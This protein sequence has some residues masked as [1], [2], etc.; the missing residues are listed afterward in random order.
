VRRA[1]F[2]DRWDVFSMAADGTG[3]QYQPPPTRDGKDRMSAGTQ[4]PAFLST[5]LLLL[6]T[7]CN[8]APDGDRDAHYSSGQLQAVVDEYLTDKT[9][10]LGTIVK[11]DIGG[12]VSYEAA[13]GFT[14]SSRT[15]PIQPDTKFIIGS[16]T[17]VFTAV[18]VHQL[19]EVGQVR[20][21]G[22]IIDY[23]PPEWSALL[24]KIEHADEITVE[25]ALGHRSGLPDVTNSD[26]FMEAAYF[27]S[28]AALK[29]L[30]VVQ[31]VQQAGELEFRP[32]EAYD[33]SNVNYLLLGGLI[34]QVSGLSY[35]QSL[36]QNILDRVGLENTLLVGKT[37]GS[38]AGVLA[39]GYTRIGDVS[40]DG[41]EINVEWAHAEGGIVS[42]AGDLIAFYRALASG[43]LFDDAGTYE[44]MCQRV[45]HNESYGRGLE[46]IDDPDIGLYY[47]HRG[48]FMSSR[49]ILAYLPEQRMTVV[50]AHTYDGFS[51]SHPADLLKVVVQSIR[52]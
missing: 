28:T 43:R 18:L 26:A 15:V 23:L 7:A 47:G 16:V 25:Q 2:T 37:Y 50:I 27:D 33:Y 12:T 4:R 9:N 49:A 11:V 20:L 3:P 19:I 38:F 30:D 34:E 21:E 29:P 31:M 52:G 36:Q 13:S 51:M 42:T 6:Y 14:D 8:G 24:E 40:Y 5:C 10:I 17:K 46:V 1:F 44:Q 35:R 22:P 39:H 45:G 32:G 41:R 48:N